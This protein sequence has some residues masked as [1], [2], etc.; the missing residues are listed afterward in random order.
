MHDR[1][2]FT[3]SQLEV[4]NKLL[5]EVQHL[6]ETGMTENQIINAL[7]LVEGWPVGAVQEAIQRCDKRRY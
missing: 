1:K 4:I 5:P 3:P 2:E 6:A 7:V